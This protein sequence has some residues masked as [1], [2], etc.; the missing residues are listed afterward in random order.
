[1]QAQIRSKMKE[2]NNMRKVIVTGGGASG[3]TAAVFAA[4]NGN[5]S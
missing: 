4:R 3:L 2:D 1:M 5:N